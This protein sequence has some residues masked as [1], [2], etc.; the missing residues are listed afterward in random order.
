MGRLRRLC[1]CKTLSQLTTCYTFLH[2]R[3]G[4]LRLGRYRRQGIGTGR[5]TGDIG[6]GDCRAIGTGSYRRL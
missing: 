3:A 4:T 1:R 5:G 6:I 2:D